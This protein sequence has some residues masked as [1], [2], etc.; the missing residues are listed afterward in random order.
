MEQEADDARLAARQPS[1]ESPLR[2]Y[3]AELYQ[4]DEATLLQRRIGALIRSANITSVQQISELA[5]EVLQETIAVALKIEERYD[6]TRSPMAWLLGIA[7][8]IVMQRRDQIYRLNRNES[9]HSDLISGSQGGQMGGVTA[10][11]RAGVMD[12]EAIMDRLL[13]RNSKSSLE[14]EVIERITLEALLSQLAADERR[15]IELNVVYEL[16]AAEVARE[17][18]IREGNARVRLTRALKKL[19]LLY[20]TQVEGQR[21]DSQTHATV[22]NS[23]R[24]PVN[25]D[26]CGVGA[27]EM[28][29]DIGSAVSGAGNDVIS[30]EEK[31]SYE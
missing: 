21:F 16:R 5:L 15:V 6:P 28:A 29:R 31:H 3:L 27:R 2:R 22:T 4:G 8:K 24:N 14:Q 18:G 26:G 7:N 23:V 12:E 10:G 30:D 13:V 11:A 20:M 19:R 25:Q 17:L 1:E 9:V